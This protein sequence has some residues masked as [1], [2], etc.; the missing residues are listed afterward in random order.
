MIQN[1]I[2]TDD[3]PVE[4][5]E[6]WLVLKMPK[7]PAHTLTTQLT[8]D[9]LARLLPAHWFINDQ[10]PITTADSE[11][12]PDVVIVRG[13]RLHYANRHPSAHDIAIMI[14]VA[15]ATLQRN[16]S[17]KKRLYARA[18]ISSYWIINL[19]ERQ[20][21][22]YTIPTTIDD[23]PD[24]QQRRDYRDEEALPIILAEL[25]IGRIRVREVIP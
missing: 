6:G 15:D 18:G 25:E 5:L 13:Q 21:E 11:S 14:E 22:V 9:A 17:N 12:E 20:I 16:R 4:L 24:Y 3:D 2:L 10:E 8:R 7:K 1:G 23:I 19:V